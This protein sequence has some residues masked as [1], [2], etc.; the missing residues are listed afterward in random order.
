MSHRR[1]DLL[2]SVGHTLRTPLNQIVDASEILHE[3]I[4][5]E[6]NERQK[7]QV[8]GV[9]AAGTELLEV[10]G[11][12]IDLA[13]LEAGTT[14]LTPTRCDIAPAIHAAVAQIRPHAYKKRI[15]LATYSDERSA[16]TN[17]DPDWIRRL[18]ATVVSNAVTIAEPRSMV[19]INFD[20][21]EDTGR[22]DANFRVTIRVH[23]S[24]LA[25]PETEDE[26]TEIEEL[27]AVYERHAQGFG[28]RLALAHAIARQHGGSVRVLHDDTT[29]H[30][31]TFAVTL[32]AGGA[33][34]CTRH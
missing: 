12:L 30:S 14:A 6:L 29:S 3:E 9:S 15:T 26:S 23:Q 22:P 7:R 16:S 5:G 27:A 31:L 13:E 1:F 25:A 24:C 20:G 28:L 8:S 11:D 17:A 33:H 19:T 4:A 32:P 2:V 10:V 18:F 34:P 21:S